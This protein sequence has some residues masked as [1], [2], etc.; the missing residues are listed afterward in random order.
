MNDQH[1]AIQ[2]PYPDAVDRRLWIRVGACRLRITRGGRDAWVSGAYDDPTGTLPCRINQEGGSARIT[3]EPRLGALPGGWGRGVPTF[4]LA[5]G[6]GQS[7]ALSIETGASDSVFELGGLPLTRLA[8]KVGAGQNV[9]RFLEPNPQSMSVLDL[10]AGAGSIEL[11]GL[12]N[13]NFA[14]MTLNGGAAAFICDFSG[15][16]QRD[17][18]V[19]LSTGM[20]ALEVAVPSMTAAR[21]SPEFTLGQLEAS[22][23]FT[24]RE[25]GYWTAAALEGRTPVLT[26]QASVA[27]GTLRLRAT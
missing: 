17:A 1:T 23:G 18:S 5:L 10:D 16:L 6:T 25:G 22:E 15:T 2:I 11:R 26:I 9:L 21:I 24:P 4:E 20:A 3:Q 27:L 14:D 12:A 7:Y 13:A 8:V 19:R